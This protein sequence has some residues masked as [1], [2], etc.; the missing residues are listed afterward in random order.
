M[1]FQDPMTSL[2]PVYKVGDQIAEAIRSH[3]SGLKEDDAKRS[4]IEL[5]E[6]GRRAEPAS[7]APTSIH[8]NSPVGCAS[9]R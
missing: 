8:T 7:S 4:A 5:L 1:I 9:E 3:D 2:N 6:L